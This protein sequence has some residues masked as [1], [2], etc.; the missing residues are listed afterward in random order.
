M[1]HIFPSHIRDV[2]PSQ[3]SLLNEVICGARDAA[4][5]DIKCSDICRINN[6]IEWLHS[7]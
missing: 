2:H 4:A 6:P 5:S 7:C 3:I 1:I